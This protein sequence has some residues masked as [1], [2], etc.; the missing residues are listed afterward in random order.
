[1]LIIVSA[2][3]RNALEGDLD[4]SA[5]PKFKRFHSPSTSDSSNDAQNKTIQSEQ[6][7]NDN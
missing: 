2:E 3:N 4:E 1:M 5:E 6:N 7:D